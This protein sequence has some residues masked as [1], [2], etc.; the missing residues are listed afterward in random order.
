MGFYLG[1]RI[2]QNS[3]FRHFCS[4]LLVLMTVTILL[5]PWFHRGFSTFRTFLHFPHSCVFSDVSAPNLTNLWEKRRVTGREKPPHS[6]QNGE[7][8]TELSTLFSLFLNPRRALFAP[9][10]QTIRKEGR[11]SSPH[12]PSQN[13]KKGRHYSPH[14]PKETGNKGGT[15][16]LV[17]AQEQGEQGALFASLC[18]SKPQGVQRVHTSG[19]TAGYI[20]QGVQYPPWYR[21]TYPGCTVPSMLPGWCIA[22][23]TSHIPGWCI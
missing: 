6:A 15:I 9:F 3:Y 13:R 22:G 10:S 17:L 21:A 4:F 5:T 20:P 18:L 8:R 2:V 11:H 7:K 19:C 1:L 14:R 16:R 12:Y 23:Y